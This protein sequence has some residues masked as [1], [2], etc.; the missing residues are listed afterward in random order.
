MNQAVITSNIIHSSRVSEAHKEWLYESI[1]G[2]L[3]IFESGFGMKS[4]M[5]RGDSFQCLVE[6]CR[7]ALR[8]GLV[9]KTF[10][11]SL[12]PW[13]GEGSPP[14]NTKNT[15]NP[16]WIFDVRMGIGIGDIDLRLKNIATSNGKAFQISGRLLDEMKTTKSRLAIGS[17]DNY[18][19]ELMM[20]STLLDTILSRTSA[21][22]CEVINLKLLGYTE[23]EI[24]RRLKIQQSAVNQR[25]ISGNW[26]VISKM[27]DYFEKIYANG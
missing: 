27:V 18:N 2:G 21:L 4:E 1:S 19:E 17:D 23:I 12:N 16:V 11:R 14:K 6:N 5:Y 15:I 8:A 3:S 25:S 22:Q 10:I 13:E 20:E 24:S 9:I 7:N 26:N